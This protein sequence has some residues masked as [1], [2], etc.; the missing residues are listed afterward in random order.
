MKPEKITIFI[1]DGHGSETPGKRSPGG[2]RENEFNRPTAV[3]LRK[4]VEDLGFKVKMVAPEIEDVPLKKRTDR[5]NTAFKDLPDDHKA[6]YI[7][8]HYNAAR[9][10]WSGAEGIE[11]YYYPGS[12]EGR[13]LA[14]AIQQELIKGTPQRNRGIKEADFHV[15]RETL[16]PAVLVEGG[17]MTNKE[18]AALMTDP[19]FQAETA[20]EI[21]AGICN[22]FGI[23]QSKDLDKSLK[24]QLGKEYNR[25]IVA[26]REVEK[27]KAQL[28]EYKN[29]FKKF[30]KFLNR[31]KGAK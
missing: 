18:E 15:L 19:E 12:T 23:N 31:A 28:K 2:T 9:S 26:E 30:Q 6:I 20:K 5:A 13:K 16:F 10:D 17:F 3:I 27:L 25:R 24:D 11:T 1:D 21:L 29:F 4:L 8:I 7:S 22:Y 14:A